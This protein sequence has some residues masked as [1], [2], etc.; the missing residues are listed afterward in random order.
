MMQG[1][2]D[3]GLLVSLLN[4][5]RNRFCH[6][7]LVLWFLFFNRILS[8]INIYAGNLKWLSDAAFTWG[9]LTL[10][11]CYLNFTPY[12]LWPQDTH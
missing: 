8:S 10:S 11:H 7:L 2:R 4:L 5:A 1:L 12:L 9:A 6:Y 3:L